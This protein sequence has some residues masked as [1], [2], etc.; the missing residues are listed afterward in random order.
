MNRATKTTM[1]AARWLVVITAI[2]VVVSGSVFAEKRAPSSEIR[3]DA[4]CAARCP[5]CV[6]KP[7]QSDPVPLAPASTRTTVVKDFQL[8]PL[9]YTLLTTESQGTTAVSDR[10]SF[11]HFS[12][13]APLFLRHCAFLI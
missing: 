7:V 3:C 9:L 4:A 2:F 1:L 8:A 13:S 6:S 10:T 5:C 11:P 12:T